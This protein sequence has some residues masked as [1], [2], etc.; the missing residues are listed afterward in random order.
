MYEVI[1]PGT[2]FKIGQLL[3]ESDLS[4][5]QKKELLESGTIV[6]FE[7]ELLFDNSSSVSVH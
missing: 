1:K 4:K 2:K 3:K 6:K 7:G 5:E